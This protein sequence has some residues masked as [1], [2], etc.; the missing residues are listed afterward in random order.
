MTVDS[1]KNA[2]IFL[3]RDGTIIEDKGH[4]SKMSEVVFFQKSFEALLRLRKNYLLFIVTNQPGVARGLISREDV[5]DVNFGIVKRLNQAGVEIADIYVCPH[6][7]LD[8]C[9]CI[10][11][12]PYFLR[13]AARYYHID[14][15]RS[16][17]IGDH[18]HDIELAEN[19]GAQG[20]Y[21]LTGHGRR[22]LA[23]LPEGAEIA[24]GIMEAAQKIIFEEEMR[25]EAREK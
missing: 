11:P 15:Q 7:R 14:L 16:F 10:K 3:D 19:A 25:K 17:V 21:L 2:A 4:L 6:D 22:H 8:N 18:P 13:K 24:A 20:I 1:K 5:N 9:A 23:E 12:N